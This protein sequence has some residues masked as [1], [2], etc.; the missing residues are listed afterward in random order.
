MKKVRC[1]LDNFKTWIGARMCDFTID[2]ELDFDDQ[3]ADDLVK[4]QPEKYEF[5]VGEQKEELRLQFNE[6][7]HEQD[8]VQAENF[9]LVES[10]KIMVADLDMNQIIALVNDKEFVELAKKTIKIDGKIKKREMLI[11]SIVKQL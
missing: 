1:K 5:V 4:W 9:G 8:A 6:L 2:H 7:K 3:L 11:E 10:F